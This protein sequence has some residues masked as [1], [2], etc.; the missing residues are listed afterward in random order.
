MFTASSLSSYSFPGYVANQLA[1]EAL[2]AIKQLCT[3]AA[4]SLNDNRG[5]DIIAATTVTTVLAFLAVVLRF[6]SRHISAAKFGMDDV[7][8]LVA[9]VRKSLKATYYYGASH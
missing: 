7:M 9:L 2:N 3:S 8:I 4:P 6:V 1:L 5:L